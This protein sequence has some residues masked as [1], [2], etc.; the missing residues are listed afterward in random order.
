M[1]RKKEAIKFPRCGADIESMKKLALTIIIGVAGVAVNAQEYTIQTIS[2]K[3][4]KSITPAF[5][6]KVHQSAL[7]SL[8]KKEGSCNIVTVGRYDTAKK[9]QADLSKAKKISPDAF[10]RP[11]ER[12][13][14][15]AC[16][17]AVAAKTEEKAVT[18]E[19]HASPKEESKPSPEAKSAVAEAAPAAVEKPKAA[20]APVVAAA[21]HAAP[22]AAEPQ[23][24]PVIVYEKI[25][26]RV[27]LTPPPQVVLYDK[28]QVRKS[29]IHEAIEYYKTSPYHSFKPAMAQL[30]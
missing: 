10:V 26:N 7:Q 8:R 23:S 21:P 28:N 29:D 30:R 20:S 16:E 12:S 22:V 19:V 9:A 14:P 18:K 1:K 2:A 13:T 4:E 27:E 6:K 17:T 3:N 24:V 11:M 15:K 5:E 25:Q